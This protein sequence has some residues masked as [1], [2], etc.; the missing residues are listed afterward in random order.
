M[1]FRNALKPDT[2][3]VSAR[4]PTLADLGLGPHWPSPRIIAA[5]RCSP[6][7]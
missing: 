3:D 4:V 5:A 1:R 7:R 2:F 6:P